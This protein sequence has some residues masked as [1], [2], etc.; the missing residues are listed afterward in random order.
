MQKSK[1]VF[2]GSSK[3][4]IP[5]IEVLRKNFDLSFI[6]TT[7]KEPTDSVPSYC[8]ENKIPFLS[9]SNLS[10]P[11]LNSKFLILN[12][13]LGVLASF[14]AII[15]KRILNA[16]P[17]GII[18]IHPS[19]L[20]KYRGPTPVQ[21][22]ILNGDKTTGA[23]IIKLDE[24]VDHGPIIV[25]KDAKI[26]PND[27]AESL[28]ERL[29]RLGA[30][31]IVQTIELYLKGEITPKEQNH[32]QATFTKRLT[33]ED[34]FIDIQSPPSS[35]ILDRMIRAYHPWPGV[36]TKLKMNPSTSLRLRG[37]DSRSSG[38]KLK[39]IKLLPENK[40]QVEGK[41]PMIY[42]DFINGYPEG[43]DIFE[44]LEY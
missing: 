32:S 31:S 36:W 3:F 15:P 33:R 28:H 8:A 10:D 25:Q 14:G 37:S 42:K 17:K 43:K 27:T 35:Q 16:F 11:I 24:E 38:K 44:K 2:F 6:V 23:T 30:G 18:N 7:E 12:S 13:Q 20:P 21:T 34:G 29:F 19:L 39:I 22:S 4:V 41:R 40:I 1:I 9:V 26:L 5:I